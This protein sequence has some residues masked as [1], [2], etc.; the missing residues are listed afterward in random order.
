MANSSSLYPGYLAYL[1][2]YVLDPPT[3]LDESARRLLTSALRASRSTNE[4]GPGF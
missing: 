3:L 1:A 2:G 4:D